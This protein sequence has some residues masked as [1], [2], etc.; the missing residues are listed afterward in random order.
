MYN[1]QLIKQYQEE[2]EEA[3]D[4]LYKGYNTLDGLGK[5][6]LDEISAYRDKV[7]KDISNSLY[8]LEE[9]AESAS[10]LSSCLNEFHK[11][12]ECLEALVSDIQK[13]NNEKEIDPLWTS[14]HKA[15]EF[16]E[17]MEMEEWDVWNK[18]EDNATI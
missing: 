16:V 12:G 6:T 7:K 15:K 8:Y 13:D 2:L 18:G 5:V 10:Y 17:T 3:H 4:E 9:L 14:Y 1:F 11:L